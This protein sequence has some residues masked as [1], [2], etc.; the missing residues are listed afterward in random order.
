MKQSNVFLLT[1]LL[2]GSIFNFNIVK[3]GV[4]AKLTAI[5][6]DA[7]AT[8]GAFQIL[9]ILNNSTRDA[10]GLINCAEANAHERLNTFFRDNKKY[11]KSEFF[12]KF[13]SNI[14]NN[15]LLASLAQHELGL[16]AKEDKTKEMLKKS[17][18]TIL[19]LL[20]VYA[21]SCPVIFR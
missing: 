7:A 3:P 17:G 11:I 12:T 13:Q 6:V 21:I 18:L 2:S 4:A 5:T 8:Y 19:S 15:R 20:A 14:N 9:T 1:I 10:E 16:K